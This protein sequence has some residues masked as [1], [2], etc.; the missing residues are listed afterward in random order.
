MLL[1][2]SDGDG[3]GDGETGEGE[4]GEGLGD[5]G[6]GRFLNGGGD[7]FLGGGGDLRRKG[8][9]GGRFFL[10]GGGVKMTA[11]VGP[12]SIGMHCTCSDHSHRFVASLNEVWLG[13][14]L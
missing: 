6:G 2:G 11:V 5:A 8:G 14:L 12:V 1:E 9:G 10:D 7:C 4:I 13:Q 3:R